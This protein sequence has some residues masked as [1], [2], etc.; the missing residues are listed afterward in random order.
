MLFAIAED[1]AALPGVRAVMTLDARVEPPTRRESLEVL[2]VHGPDEAQHRVRELARAC[3]GTL[4]IAP[5]TGG[6]LASAVRTVLEA[7]GRHLGASA[8]AIERASDKLLLPAILERAG[9]PG[10][11]AGPWRP[12]GP[13]PEEKTVVKPRRGAGSERVVLLDGTR[14][15]PPAGDGEDLIA[16]PYMEGIAASVLVIS[17]REG[18]A[19]L[20]A[21]AQD[22][23]PSGDFAY[24]GGSL[25][26]AAPLEARARRLALAAVEAIPGLAGF[27]GVDMILDAATDRA[28]EPREVVVEVNARLT[29][30]YV[31]LRAH[32]R[33]N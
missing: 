19:P 25:P 22:L 6:I 24:L 17:G 18:V 3:D 8:E 13:A 10:I 20:R 9:I 1:I 2:P 26:L 12:G 15:P 5:E 32:A 30:S 11:P 4:V 21:C 14:S 33:T 27:A 28:R 31:G 29:T 7:G 23:S 16:T